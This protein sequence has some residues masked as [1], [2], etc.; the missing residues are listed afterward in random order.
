[1]S[2]PLKVVFVFAGL[3][4]IAGLIEILVAPFLP[5]GRDDRSRPVQAS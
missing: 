3:V 2:K 1:M 4:L 5:V